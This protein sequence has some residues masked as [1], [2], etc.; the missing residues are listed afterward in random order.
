M[1]E[2][3]FNAGLTP[4]KLGV[5]FE[6]PAIVLIYREKSKLRSRRIPAKDVDILTNVTLFAEKFKENPKNKRYF[7]KI[8][9]NKIERIVFLLQDNM[10]GYTL[11]ESLQRARKFDDDYQEESVS[12]TEEPTSEPT[13]TDT[14]LD[15]L[16]NKYNVKSPKTAFR[17]DSDENLASLTNKMDARTNMSATP[18]TPIT[19]PKKKSNLDNSHSNSIHASEK[20]DDD[21]FHDTEDEEEKNPPSVSTIEDVKAKKD[22]AKI[23][24]FNSAPYGQSVKSP[25][26]AST[27][28]SDK[29]AAGLINASNKTNALDILTNQFKSNRPNAYDFEDDVD[30]EEIE[31]E[32][33][34]GDDDDEDDEVSLEKKIVKKAN[35]EKFETAQDGNLSDSSF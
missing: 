4:I 13:G 21:D 35:A 23:T 17:S 29:P 18:T 20:Y 9:I 8:A 16:K 22:Q 24:V 11:K 26:S 2:I 7:E 31:E 28:A 3:A 27:V 12:Q 6:P 25:G 5:R 33:N 30:D 10:K 32:I 15:R 1:S 34:D 19:T 14:T